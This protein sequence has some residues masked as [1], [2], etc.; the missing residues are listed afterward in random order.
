MAAIILH[1]DFV[2]SEH[3]QFSPMQKTPKGQKIV[4]INNPK[5]KGKVRLQTPTMRAPFGLSR[6]DDQT[7]GNASFSL[8]IS[9]NGRDQ[10]PKLDKFLQTCKDLDQ[11]MLEM[12]HARS[13]EWFGKDMSMNILREFYRPIV[14]EPSNPKYEPTI[15]LKMTPYSEIYD[16][17]KTRV[18]QDTLVKGCTLKAIVEPSFWLVNKSFGISL[19]VVQLAVVSRPSGIS[20]FA[21]A[22]EEDESIPIKEEPGEGDSMAMAFMET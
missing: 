7:T 12:A 10:N 6:F 1:T 3:M 21:F 5:N 8:D 15:R 17:N 19:R 22:E 11:Y 9:F 2:P 13:Q 20:G 4:Y 14:R 18:E 16:E